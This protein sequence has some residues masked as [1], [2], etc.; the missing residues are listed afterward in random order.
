ME[1]NKKN[2]VFL[3]IHGHF[4]QPPR[5]NPWLEAI[6]LQD[7]ALPFH[8]WN[9]R[10]NKECYNP[11]SVSKIVDSRNRILD[12][13]N[14]YEH[15]SFNFGPTLLSWM[16]K[17]APLTYERIIK[18]DIESIS[19]H[20]GHGNAIAQVYNHMIMPLANEHD[21]DTQIKWGIKDF[22]YRFGRKPEGMWLAETAVDDDTLRLLE[23]NGIKFTILSPYQALKIRKEGAKEWQDVSWGNVDPARSYR[24]N[25]KSAP[26]KYIDLFFYDGA[27]SRSVAFDELLKDGNKF[28]KRLKEGISDLRDYPQL[29]NIATDGESYGHHTKFGDMALAYVLQIKAKDAGFSI[30]N[31]AEY[32]DKYR[33]DY[34]A[35]IKQASSWSCFH[36]VGRWKEDCGCSTG[37]HPGWN[38]K[39]RKPLREAL[40]YLRDEMVKIFEQEGP[41]YFNKDIWEVRNNYISVILDRSSRI[42]SKFQQENFKA[43][44]SDIQ[45]VRAMELLEIQRQAM[46]MY[47]SCG[48]FFSEIS[49]IET[50]QIMKYAARA[51][52]LAANFTKADFEKKFLE[53][54]SEAKSNIAEYG[55]GKDIFERFV[56]PSII[57][58]KQ[59]ASLWAISSL[60][61]D[62][63]DEEYVYC[64]K[65]IRHD[66]QKVEK[67]NSRFVTGC[68][69]VQS[70][71]T[72]QKSNLIFALIQYTDGDFH[73]AIKEYSEDIEFNTIKNNLTKTF[74]LDPITEIIRALDEYFGKEYFTLKDIFIEERRKILQILLK[75][76]LD[77]F[78]RTY[79]EMYDEGKSSI[80]HMQNLGLTIPDEFKISAGYALSRKFNDLIIHSGGFVDPAITQQAMD[81]NYEAKR[82][83]IKLDKAASNKIFAKK[84][85]QNLNRLTYGLEIQQAEVVLELFDY[86][87]KLELEVDIA[88]AQNIYFV[89]IYSHISEIIEMSQQSKRKNDK[90]LIE[91]LLD[92][93]EKLNINTD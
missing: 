78:A 6:E 21:K 82:M 44:L 33:S 43:D 22:E 92:I 64:Y 7:S 18:A 62:F 31:Y 25:I 17:F 60:Y 80:Y 91:M 93:G 61:Q 89:K 41:K 86:I 12:M 46:L 23:A 8:D 29:V 75:D 72:Q 67:G 27:I 34:E 73:C 30:T 13:V 36:G 83:G 42:I 71:I 85:N 66:Y 54:L 53:I 47:T 88:E 24:Y 9:E 45:K 63:D 19:E 26:G 87:E 76:K 65:V 51:M 50:V 58:M 48:W 70:R 37:G 14:N 79:E 16:E 49:G 84:I 35:D 5:E 77:K 57:T 55:T 1:N 59:I 40:D 90:K 56:K 3:A 28:I 69:E 52:Q 2:E 10:I 15:I 68:I 81:I 38:Q 4:Y 39:W 11:N 32:L 74:L 20:N